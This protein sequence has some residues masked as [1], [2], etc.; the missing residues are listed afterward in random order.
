MKTAVPNEP[1]T[2]SGK[3]QGTALV[4][5]TIVALTLMVLLAVFLPA[6][7]SSSSQPTPPEPEPAPAPG[8]SPVPP[9]GGAIAVVRT[10]LEQRRIPGT[11]RQRLAPDEVRLY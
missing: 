6:F 8:P 3:N 4:I 11:T 7:V 2:A 5:L 1:Q 9:P 10:D